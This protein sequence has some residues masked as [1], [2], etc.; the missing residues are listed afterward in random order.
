MSCKHEEDLITSRGNYKVQLQL[1]GF[2]K[3]SH[4]NSYQCVL[5]N[6]AHRRMLAEIEIWKN[7]TL[8]IQILPVHYTIMQS[9]KKANEQPYILC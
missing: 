6:F 4:S 8:K 3:V 1:I 9:A 7:R 5:G 2:Y